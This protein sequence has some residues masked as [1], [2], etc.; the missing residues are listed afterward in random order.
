[1]RELIFKR[2]LTVIPLMLLLSVFCFALIKTI[3][4][5]PVDIL[6]GGA[7][8]DINPVELASLRQEMGLNEPIYKQYL[9][10]LGGFVGKGELGRSY[11]DGRP[12]LTVIGERLPATMLLV[13][14]A[15]AL[16]FVLG[17]FWGLVLTLLPATDFADNIRGIAIALALFLYSA[18]SFWLAYLALFA[19]AKWCPAIP[20]LSLHAPGQSFS[21]LQFLPYVFLPAL[22]LSLRRSAKIALFIRSSIQQELQKDYVLAA[23]SKGLSRT[24]VLLRHVFVNSVAPII[25]LI[26]L[27]LPALLGGSV[28]IETVFGWPGMGRLTV[29]AAFG[30][31]YPILMGLTMI[32]GA[33]V[34]ASNLL[35][36]IAQALVDPTLREQLEDPSG[37]GV[38]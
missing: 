23:L 11:K 29:E 13:G 2:I 32:Y 33:I 21:C 7:Q 35:A 15:L 20:I 10:W 6:I 24:Q 34:V 9:S 4:G 18:P 26:G 8:R 1:M 30:R 27:S 28:L 19:V 36:D 37:I 22:I 16:A 3:P 38:T 31:N 17:V 14:S 12:V 25:T 5:D